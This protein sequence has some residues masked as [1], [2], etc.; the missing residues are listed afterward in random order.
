MS[1]KL[2]NLT[3]TRDKK[4]K[5]YF[6]NV[7]LE[8]IKGE[9]FPNELQYADIKRLKKGDYCDTFVGDEMCTLSPFWRVRRV[10]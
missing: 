8:F 4:L 2:F 1:K 6:K 10:R 9:C 3:L 7:N 5:R